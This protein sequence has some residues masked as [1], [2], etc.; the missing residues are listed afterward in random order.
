MGL[1]PG[2]YIPKNK[3]QTSTLEFVVFERR[4]QAVFVVR[5][6]VFEFGFDLHFF[7]IGFSVLWTR[8]TTGDVDHRLAEQVARRLKALALLRSELLTLRERLPLLD[9]CLR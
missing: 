1:P 4:G 2:L 6:Q 9:R 5:K 7:Q 3:S 8:W